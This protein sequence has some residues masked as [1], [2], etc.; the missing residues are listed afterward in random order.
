MLDALSFLIARGAHVVNVTPYGEGATV[1]TY[2]Q[3]DEILSALRRAGGSRLYL[4]AY[5]Y[6]RGD[7]R[8]EYPEVAATLT[9]RGFTRVAYDAA[10]GLTEWRAP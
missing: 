10:S 2:R 1:V 9:Q 5:L 8:P 7:S 4:A 3:L 6:D